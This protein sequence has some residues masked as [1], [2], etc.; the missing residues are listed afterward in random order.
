MVRVCFSSF[1]LEIQESPHSFT[2]K[3]VAIE[4]TRR[5]AAVLSLRAVYIIHARVMREIIRVIVSFFRTG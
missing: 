3:R 5:S 1:S 4:P 2:A